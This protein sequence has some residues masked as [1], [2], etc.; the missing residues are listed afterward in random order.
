M[1]KSILYTVITGQILIFIYFLDSSYVNKFYFLTA[2]FITVI[3]SVFIL[4]FLIEKDKN[5]LNSQSKNDFIALKSFLS[6]IV[7]DNKTFFNNVSEKLD[8]QKNIS[9]NQ[10]NVSEKIIKTLDDNY[11]G[12][13]NKL[14]ELSKLIEKNNDVLFNYFN[15]LI[16]NINDYREE[17][18][19]L[20]LILNDN[21][22][23]FINKFSDKIDKFNETVLSHLKNSILE[24][25]VATLDKNYENFNNNFIKLS[26]NLEN[27]YGELF[28]KFVVIGLSIEELI[29][30][31][32]TANADK[33]KINKDLLVKIEDYM[34]DFKTNIKDFRRKVDESNE[35]FLDNFSDKIDEFNE[36]V[37]NKL[38]NNT[39][40]IIGNLNKQL[41]YLENL[42]KSI[43]EFNKS[44]QE[45]IKKLFKL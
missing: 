45:L 5:I 16:E 10:Y 34:S 39:V 43:V 36:A 12:S 26:K 42:N 30:S 41:D 40:E 1:K 2:D 14:T 21:S 35:E 44:D 17:F 29:K 28:K 9:L 13:N 19:Q 11:E 18:N 25:I 6:N 32:E 23:D 22:K 7:E 15:K 8:E 31:I 38:K 3:A 24:K 27:N 20:K 33:I 4:S 37:Q